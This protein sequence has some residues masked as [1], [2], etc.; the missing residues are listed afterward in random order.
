MRTTLRDIWNWA[1]APLI[2]AASNAGAGAAVGSL[3]GGTGVLVGAAVGAVLGGIHGWRMAYAH[4][5]DWTTVVGVL[6]FVADNTWGLPN[7]VVGSL[8]ATAN[9]FNGIAVETSRASGTLYHTHGWFG[10]YDTTL[11]NVTVGT[12]VPKHEAVHALQARLFGP[13]YYPL[14]ILSYVIDTFLPY[15]LLYHN[16]AA[17]PITS[18]GKYF[19]CG[20]Y[21]HTW[22]EEWAYAVDGEAPC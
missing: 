13:A 6:A 17:R 7:S 20:V 4:T 16:F 22:F 11:G 14:F 15:W 9:V 10:S 8:F 5:Y 3:G 21:P 1:F 2:R 18:F 19:K 12:I